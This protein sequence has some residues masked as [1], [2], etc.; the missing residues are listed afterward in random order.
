M[1]F[2]PLNIQQQE[3]TKALKGY[4]AEEVRTFLDSVANSYEDLLSENSALKQ[5]IEE[6]KRKNSEFKKIEKSL[7]DTLLNAHESSSK[8]VEEAKK[9]TGTLVKE[10]EERAAKILDNAKREAESIK[11]SVSKLRDEKHLLI[12]RLK[13]IIESQAGILNIGLSDNE[14]RKEPSENRNKGNKGGEDQIDVDE[15]VEKLL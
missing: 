1:K 13:G 11:N 14:D 4:K 6:L 9:K 7:Q 3:F 12:S 8:A 2:T 5:E 10:A 15:I